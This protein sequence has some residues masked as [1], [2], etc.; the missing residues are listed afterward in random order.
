MDLSYE[1]CPPA[2]YSFLQVW[3]LN[4]PSIQELAPEYQHDLARIIC[5]LEP[6]A[7]PLNPTL[8][9]IAA[10]LRAVAIEISQRRTFQDRYA[11]DLQAA[12]DAGE[13]ARGDDGHSSAGSSRRVV[14]SF[15]PPPM[16]EP[17][18]T[19]S[20]NRSPS[21]AIVSLPSEP[22][23]PA[24]PRRSGTFLQPPMSPM[25]SRG[26]RDSFVSGSAS[27]RS[28]TPSPSSPSSSSW[29]SGGP[30]S[31]SFTVDAPAIQLIRETLY[32]S[33]GDVISTH[34]YIRRLMQRDPPRAYFA[35]VA[36]AILD[37]ALTRT[38]CTLSSTSPTTTYSSP[39]ASL[40]GLPSEEEVVVTGILGANLTLSQCPA[41]LRPFMRELGAI[42]QVVR[43]AEEEDNQL[44]IEAITQGKD[45]PAPRV[46]RVRRMLER[47]IGSE[48]RRQRSMNDDGD[49]D[50]DPFQGDSGRRSIEGR[51][52]SLA[53]RINA[54]ALGMTKLKPF[55]ERQNEI[56]KILAN[57][58]S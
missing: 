48:H 15:V 55:R 16:Y 51:A 14:A 40:D 58:R 19:P 30:P 2:F 53:N 20:P 37:V 42:G 43:E 11:A 27:S 23:F 7:Q 26:G 18:P 50:M 31:P 52:I 8:N 49:D 35:S 3:A 22:E 38:T 24:S 47:G 29:T 5:T 12:L 10:E 1:N 28:R 4:V 21:S 46:D 25:S 33:L 13:G 34:P 36:L 56:F 39:R 32:A 17:S 41:P 57:V 54:L 9:G 44:A 6:I 45:L